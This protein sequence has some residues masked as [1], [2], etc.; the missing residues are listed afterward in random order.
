MADRFLQ[1]SPWPEPYNHF[2]EF[3]LLLP[4]TNE[5]IDHPLFFCA[6][7]PFLCNKRRVNRFHA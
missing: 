6:G 3:G 1:E 5:R 2:A 7:Q 4:C